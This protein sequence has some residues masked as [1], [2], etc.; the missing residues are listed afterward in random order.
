[1]AVRLDGIEE[2]RT[3]ILL[4]VQKPNTLPTAATTMPTQQMIRPAPIDADDAAAR[5]AP[6][7]PMADASSIRA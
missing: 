5:L 4:T 1:M 6:N 3:C 2:A 7:P